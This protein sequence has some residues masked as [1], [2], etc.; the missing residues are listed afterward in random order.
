MPLV[1]LPQNL[2]GVSVDHN[3]L[4]GG[5]ADIEPDK[6]LGLLIMPMMGIPY[7]LN[8]RPR[9]FERCNLNQ[10]WAFMIVHEVPLN[11]KSITGVP[12]F[13]PVLPEVGISRSR[14][15]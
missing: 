5:R 12:H 14:W 2:V 10:L 13:W 8:R 9:S 6:E 7:L 4:D 15:S 3:C 11:S 1:V